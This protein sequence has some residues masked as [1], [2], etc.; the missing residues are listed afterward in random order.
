MQQQNEGDKASVW[1]QLKNILQQPLGNK[2]L[3]V[4]LLKN[5]KSIHK[6]NFT[7]DADGRLSLNF[8]IPKSGADNLALDIRDD[9]SHEIN[10]PLLLH[11]PEDIDLQFMPEGGHLVAGYT[12][13]IGFKAIGEDGKGVVVKGGIYNSQRQEVASFQSLHA[14]MGSFF[15]KARKG[16]KYSARLYFPDSSSK[17]YA[18]P[19]VQPSGTLLQVKKT[20]GKDS[21]Q[22]GIFATT[23]IAS[24]RSTFILLGQSSGGQLLYHKELQLTSKGTFLSVAT[25][26]FPEGV[27]RFTLMDAGHRPLNE[28]LVFVH[29]DNNLKINLHTDKAVYHPHDSIALHIEVKDASG[30]PI[31]GNFSVAVTDDNQ[32]KIDSNADNIL[33][34]FHLSSCLKGY[35]EDPFYYFQHSDSITNAALDNLLLTQ[36]W[37]GYDWKTIFNP[38]QKPSFE[39]EKTFEV[40]G[41][42]VNGINKPIKNAKVSLISQKPT[43]IRTMNTNK[44][45]QFT[46]KNFPPIDTPRFFIQALNKRGKSFSVGINM[47]GF[48]PPSLQPIDFPLALPWNVNINETLSNYITDKRKKQDEILK[49]QLAGHVLKP[50]VVKAKKA[51]RNSYN[52]NGPGKADIVLDESDIKKA[53][54]ISLRDFLR[55]HIPGLNIFDTSASLNGYDVH[56]IIEGMTLQYIDSNITLDPLSTLTTN[57]VRGIEIMYSPQYVISYDARYVLPKDPKFLLKRKRPAA[58]IEIT[59]KRARTLWEQKKPG[60]SVYIPMPIAW[61]KKFYRPRYAKKVV[62]LKNSDLRATIH[63]EPNVDMETKGK[64]I[65]TFYAADRP[66]TYTVILE[67]SDMKGHLG[68]ASV[69]IQILEK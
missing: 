19:E 32:V 11:R 41:T 2:D 18:L 35:V 29:H 44:D 45:G 56:F 64:G 42:V 23:D 21:L 47:D 31:F 9:N 22:I 60:V 6:N 57:D 65:V 1:L 52:L 43:L 7:T 69:K 38:P 28:R 48:K 25:R 39:A 50:V 27:A 46:F 15:L 5:G 12:Q 13:R 61:P 24:Q 53:G 66:S 63:W 58:Y 33:S 62:G 14:G 36:G 49:S 40:K 54:N 17:L 4:R 10:I 37:V 30:Q 3:Q 55:Q 59:T 67:G 8:D 68:Y 51:I 34:Y 26:L 16:E 20:T